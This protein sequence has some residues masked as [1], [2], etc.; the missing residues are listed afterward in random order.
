MINT[1]AKLLQL[2]REINSQ[3]TTTFNEIELSSILRMLSTCN[4]EELNQID[5]FIYD[6]LDK[7]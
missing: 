3:E 5:M 1:K 6:L 2:S 4:Y 7:E